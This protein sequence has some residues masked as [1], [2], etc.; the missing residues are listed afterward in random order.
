M[1]PYRDNLIHGGWS[2]GVVCLVVVLCIINLPLF[3]FPEFHDVVVSAGGFVPILFSEHAFQSSYR[4]ITAAILH[5]DIFHL[6]GNCLFLVVF[7]RALERLFGFRLLL[8]L[9]PILG[10]PGFIA[11]WAMHAASP[12]PVIGASGAIAT[13]MGAYLPLFPHARI[14]MLLWL[15]WLWKRFTL[16]AW[17][18]LPYWMGLQLL[19]IASGTYDGIAYAVHAGCFAAGVIAAIVWKTAYI[20]ADV[21]LEGFKEIS[22]ESK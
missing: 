5:G 14:R 15:G 20:G 19:S 17:V 16:P 4:L 3:L 7:G 22:F 10:I 1:F 18:F 6:A 21:K 2:I 9:F 8:I 13:L 11:E 12:A